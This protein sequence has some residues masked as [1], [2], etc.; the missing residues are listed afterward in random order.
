[1]ETLSE[2]KN[3]LETTTE[4]RNAFNRGV[5]WAQNWFNLKEVHP[6]NYE[7]VLCRSAV[8]DHYIGFWV[9]G[10]GMKTDSPANITHWRPI[11]RL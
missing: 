4:A 1:M 10:Y 2:A 3:R 8:N 5:Q 11:E 6:E 7:W 9:E